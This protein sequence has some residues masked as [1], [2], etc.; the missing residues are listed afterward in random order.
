MEA[1][2]ADGVEV[3]VEPWSPRA[4]SERCDDARQLEQCARGLRCTAGVCARSTALE[5][6]SLRAWRDP[7]GASL[8]LRIG[9][10]SLGE[11]VTPAAVELPDGAGVVLASMP[12]QAVL[13]SQQATSMVPFLS[14]LTA[15]S[16]RYVA[17]LPRAARVRVR[18]TDT[19]S[20]TSAPFEAALE[21]TAVVGVG[22]A[23]GDPSL[24]CGE[25]LRCSE[26]S[27]T[28]EQRCVPAPAPRACDLSARPGTWAPPSAGTWTIEGTSRGGGGGTSCMASRTA[29]VAAAE[30][31]APTSGRYVFETRGLSVLDLR[32][33]CDAPEPTVQCLRDAP[34][35]RL[36]VDLRAGER[37]SLA[38]MAMTSGEPFAVT[39]RV[40]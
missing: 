1:Q 31:V 5:V 34:D 32:R 36:E 8:R 16:E 27:S 26:F 30:F 40:P 22:E 23:C 18:V 29:G 15:S 21:T 3:A 20:R 37:M 7:A 28:G 25:A 17:A 19:M 14:A 38:V 9:G 10:Q 4:V 35:P 24:S 39:V 11:T 33:A 6:T 12:A 13:T 2:V